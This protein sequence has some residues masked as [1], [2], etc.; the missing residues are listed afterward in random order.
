MSKRAEILQ[1]EA[2]LGKPW[3]QYIFGR[4]RLLANA[5]TE[6][7]KWLRK[8]ARA[9]HPYAFYDFAKIFLAGNGINR[10][11]RLAKSFADKARSLHSGM[12]LLCNMM[13]LDIAKEYISDG[14]ETEANDVLLSIV[15]ETDESALDAILCSSVGARLANIN[16]SADM[17]VRAFCYGHIESALLPSI[18]F[19]SCEKHALSKLWLDVACRSKSFYSSV[20]VASSGEM[21][22]WA[23]YN[24][25]RNGTRSKLRQMRNPCGGCGAALA[26]DRR[27]YCRCCRTYCYSPD[28]IATRIVRRSIGTVAT[29]RNAERWRSTCVEFFV[30]FVLVSLI[31]CANR[32][33]SEVLDFVS[34]NAQKLCGV[35]SMRFCS[36][37]ARGSRNR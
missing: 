18:Q 33:Q 34:L 24:S 5:P 13:Q 29:G 8:A 37:I 32:R 11:L 21:L 20:K 23:D 1:Q 7:F 25:N 35:S 22:G 19:F 28:C 4:L 15:Q 14:D 10:D 30:L 16:S 12:G 9:G 2:Q 36:E 26:G 27:K 31:R 17:Y 3:A 6:S